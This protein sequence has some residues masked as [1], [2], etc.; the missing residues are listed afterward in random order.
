MGQPPLNEGGNALRGRSPT[1]SQPHARIGVD[2]TCITWLTCVTCSQ[3]LSPRRGGIGVFC[4]L[5]LYPSAQ[6]SHTTR[7]S[8]HLRGAIVEEG[9]RDFCFVLGAEKVAVVSVGGC[10]WNGVARSSD[11]DYAAVPKIIAH[12]ANLVVWVATCFR[13]CTRE[14]GLSQMRSR[15][16]I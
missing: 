16:R 14:M 2:S 13:I 12:H 7:R 9:S 5:C 8:G 1:H 15:K 10:R 4:C 6:G 11:E 3:R